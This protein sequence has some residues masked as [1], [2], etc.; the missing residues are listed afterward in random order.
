M[1]NEAHLNVGEFVSLGVVGTSGRFCVA[2]TVAN[3]D[4]AEWRL[5]QTQRIQTGDTP[6]DTPQRKY[7]VEVC[8]KT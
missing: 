8:H 6:Q 4:P 7:I 2:V 5:S 3:K 1:L